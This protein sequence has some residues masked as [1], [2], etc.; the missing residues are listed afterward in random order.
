MKDTTKS[1][2]KKVFMYSLTPIMFFAG[3]GTRTI[4]KQTSANKDTVSAES[5]RYALVTVG[6]SVYS[7]E[8]ASYNTHTTDDLCEITFKKP[9][10]VY[11]DGT[12]FVMTDYIKTNTKNVVIIYGTYCNEQ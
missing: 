11:V 2:L 4:I 8:I 7:G 9:L 12:G 6:G 10:E 1:K 5:C 3:C